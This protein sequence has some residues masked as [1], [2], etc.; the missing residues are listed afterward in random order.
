MSN[1]ENGVLI[2]DNRVYNIWEKQIVSND[3]NYE[4]VSLIKNQHYK[5]QLLWFFRMI[6]SAE[7]KTTR[8]LYFFWLCMWQELFEQASGIGMKCKPAISSDIKIASSG[9]IDIMDSLG[10]DDP[11][12]CLLGKIGPGQPKGNETTLLM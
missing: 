12:E 3:P 2:E 1:L 4:F 10:I 6:S 7:E 5:R 8:R 9:I 11:E